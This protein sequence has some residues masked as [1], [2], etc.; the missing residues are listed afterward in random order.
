MH[1][2][3]CTVPPSLA[4]R[5]EKWTCKLPGMER[6]ECFPA[7]WVH[8]TEHPDWDMAYVHCEPQQVDDAV[9]VEEI[10]SW[11]YG[12]RNQAGRLVR[13]TW[14]HPASLLWFWVVTKQL[15]ID[16][17]TNCEV[18]GLMYL[19]R[20]EWVPPVQPPAVVPSAGIA[21]VAHQPH[22]AAS[23]GGPAVQWSARHPLL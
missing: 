21:C 7:E 3:A 8:A 13:I 14:H 23:P 17:L 10:D 22:T 20:G 15:S 11:L 18:E 19:L 2:Q 12:Y 4:H 1:H 16:S 5:G 6:Q 9:A